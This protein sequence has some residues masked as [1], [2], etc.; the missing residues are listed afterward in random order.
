[1]R[2]A[3]DAQTRRLFRVLPEVR[4]EL[5]AIGKRPYTGSADGRTRPHHLGVP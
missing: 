3:G 5:L 2:I 1:M 4:A